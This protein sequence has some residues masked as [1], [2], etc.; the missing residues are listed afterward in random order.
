[1]ILHIQPPTCLSDNW[2]FMIAS[3]LNWSRVQNGLIITISLL[4]YPE[5]WL[6]G[7]RGVVPVRAAYCL[8]TSRGAGPNI[9]KTSIIPDSE[10][11]WESIC[12]ISSPPFTKS[13]NFD[14]RFYNEKEK[15]W[16]KMKGT[17]AMGPVGNFSMYFNSVMLKYPVF[18]ALLS[19]T[20]EDQ[21]ADSPMCRPDK[22][23]TRC[24][25]WR[26]DGYQTRQAKC[27]SGSTHGLTWY[28]FCPGSSDN[29]LFFSFFPGFIYFWDVQHFTNICWC[30][31]S[32]FNFYI[33]YPN[34]QWEFSKCL[35]IPLYMYINLVWV[36]LQFS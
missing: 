30:K 14:I 34:D 25:A 8:N 11:Q 24:E 22:Y 9:K 18:W 28:K 27:V 13:T 7:G 3:T 2:L 4:I 1:M 5:Y 20:G 35:W 31:V 12:G 23:K 32:F 29:H 33:D 6:T 19:W 26:I 16:N 10:Y 21:P 17:E 15:K 36:V